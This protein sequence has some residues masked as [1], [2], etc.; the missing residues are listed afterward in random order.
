MG[1]FHSK[2]ASSEERNK[3]RDIK[4]SIYSN[5]VNQTAEGRY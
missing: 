1:E 3:Q 2:L 4:I 5:C